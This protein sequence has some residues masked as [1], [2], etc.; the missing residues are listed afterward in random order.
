MAVLKSPMKE[1]DCTFS[2]QQNFGG[3]ILDHLHRHRNSKLINGTIHQENTYGHLAEQAVSVHAALGNLGLCAGSKIWVLVSN[4]TELVPLIVGAACANVA[5]AYEYPGYAADILNDWKTDFNFDALFCEYGDAEAF[6]L[7]P[8]LPSVKHVIVLGASADKTERIS[9]G[10]CTWEEF[11]RIGEE[12]RVKV[13]PRIEYIE[14]QFCYA[15]LTSGT[16]GKPKMVIHCH[17]SL[18]ANVQASSHP[19][20]MGLNDRDFLLYTGILGH[21][22][23][24]FDC[25]CKGIVQGA[26]TV[27]L[28]SPN[29]NDLLK[30]LEKQKV[31]ALA[32]VPYEAQRLLDHPQRTKHDLS[33][34]QYLITA[35]NYISEDLARRLFNDL[36]LKSYAQLYGQT[37]FIF[38]TGG[39]HDAP[40]RYGSIG[41]LGMGVEAMVV[42]DETGEPLGPGQPGEL[43]IRG[44]G[45]MRGYWGRL[46]E[47]VTDANGWYRTGDECYYDEEEWLY[48]VQRLTEFIHFGNTKIAPSKIEAVLLNCP[49]V[50]DC[51][52]VG[53]PSPEVGELPHA[54]VVPKPGYEH[55]GPEHFQR[56]VNAKVPMFLKLEGGVTIVTE[57][58]RNRLGKL[59]RRE[60][61]KWVIERRSKDEVN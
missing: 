32:T 52:L 57:I 6:N 2:I 50:Q 60:L 15:H 58:P 48:L 51:A 21:V 5:F 33:N 35:T 4:R 40:P 27:F 24:L 28:E 17:E 3:F 43:L 19:R 44:P 55:L 25:V 41:R 22:Y 45:L 36:K 16:T 9:D 18:V 26:S 31:S 34:L 39:L 38:V 61:R 59:Q 8:S 47:P 56:F 53:L 23:G 11:L 37:E 46:D 14:G 1:S 42:D 13:E 30:A 54:V 20:H 29:T 12:S 49:E 7:P 10:A